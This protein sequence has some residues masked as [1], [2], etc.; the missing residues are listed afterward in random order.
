V[1]ALLAKIRQAMQLKGVARWQYL[2]LASV[3]SLFASVAYLFAEISTGVNMGIITVAGAALQGIL[4]YLFM[5]KKGEAG[6]VFFSLVFSLF[7][8]ILGKYLIFEHHYDWF[9]SAYIDKSEL[10]LSLVIFYIQA[11]NLDSMKLFIAE[12]GVLFSFVD[13]IFMITII[14]FAMLHLILDF[15]IATEK[16]LNAGRKKFNKRRFD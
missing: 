15:N 5:N 4:A 13:F 9:L 14:A 7:S 16:P 11:I 8:F 6:L 2:L 1:K 10:S 3:F 12:G